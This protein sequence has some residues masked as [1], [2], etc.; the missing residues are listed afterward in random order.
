MSPDDWRKHT[1]YSIDPCDDIEPAL[2]N[3]VHIK[4]YG[5]KGCLVTDFDPESVN[6][7][8]YTMSFLGTL[9]WWKRKRKRLVRQELAIAEETPVI[10]PK[11]SIS[12]LLT[13]QEFRLPQYIAARFNLHIRHVHKGILLGTGPLVDPGFAGPLLI[14]LHNLT[15]NDYTIPGGNPIIWVEFTKLSPLDYWKRDIADVDQCPPAGFVTF[16]DEKYALTAEKYFDKALNRSVPGVQSAFKGA[17][18]DAR[19]AAR[20]ADKTTKYVQR[21]GFVA[22]AALLVA[23]LALTFQAVSLI[24]DANEIHAS[25]KALI[26]DLKTATHSAN[27]PPDGNAEPTSNQPTN[28]A[29]TLPAYDPGRVAGAANRSDR[30]SN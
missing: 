17:L 13:E 27:A 14:P 15:D 10:L 6:P 11:N 24:V 23:V 4:C 26:Q 12:Y 9:Y 1:N 30:D 16:L 22:G 20:S 8:S 7:A 5:R 29:A 3:S 28:A 21:I 18:D 25:A 2:L 19:K